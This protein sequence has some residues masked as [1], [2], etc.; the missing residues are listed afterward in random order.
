MAL[1]F[2]PDRHETNAYGDPVPAH[3]AGNLL[4]DYQPGQR[5]DAGVADDRRQPHRPGLVDLSGPAGSMVGKLDLS[6]ETWKLGQNT[7]RC[8]VKDHKAPAED[9]TCGLRVVGPGGY[10]GGDLRVRFAHH[11]VTMPRA[12]GAVIA[13]PAWANHEVTAVQ[14]G[15]RWALICNA[16]RPKTALTQ[17]FA[18]CDPGIRLSC[19]AMFTRGR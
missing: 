5:A 12:R 9:C 13:M 8:L 3:R 18:G 19:Y 10:T 7:A 15:E 6:I 2:Q 11:L 17:P 14:A 4:Y 16:N 1:L